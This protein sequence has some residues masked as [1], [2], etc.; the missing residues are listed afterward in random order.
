M[1]KGLLDYSDTLVGRLWMATRTLLQMLQDR[2]YNID[3]EKDVPLFSDFETKMRPLDLADP[4]KS[5]H[6]LNQLQRTIYHEPTGET[7]EVFWVCG[8]VGK[9]SDA[10]NDISRILKEKQ[11]DGRT[12]VI[13]I[14]VEQ[15]SISGPARD[16]LRRHD[17]TCLEFFDTG[18]LLRNIM[19]HRLQPKFRILTESEAEKVK[20]NYCVT[21]DQL[22]SLLWEDNVRR[23]LGLKVGDVVRIKRLADGGH[24]ISYRIVQARQVGKKKKYK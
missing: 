8:K 22:P 19:H 21:S 12:V 24:D 17:D 4:G 7:I 1:E 11:R 14:Q 6:L 18:L 10:V 16:E 9:N 13:V 5:Q 15:C 2:G 20:K 23:Y 3:W